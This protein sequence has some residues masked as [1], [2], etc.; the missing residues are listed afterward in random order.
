MPELPEVELQRQR[1]NGWWLGRTLLELHTPDPD[2]L[3][4]AHG[5]SAS[6]LIG[7]T[8]Q[9]VERRAKRLALYF[10]EG[11]ALVV[12]F[13]MT[14]KF[15]RATPRFARLRFVLSDD[16]EILYKDQRRLGHLHLLPHTQVPHALKHTQLG[17][18]PWPEPLS[19]E[20]LRTLFHQ[21]TRRIKEVLLDQNVIAGLGNIAASEILWRARITPGRKASQLGLKRLTRLGPAMVDHIE[22]TLAAE[23]GEEIVFQGEAGSSNPFLIYGR[24]GEPCPRCKSAL[25]QTRHGQRST[26]YCSTCQR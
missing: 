2:R 22:H 24:T 6:Q 16:T 17:P 13:R 25:R 8:L 3:T 11:L 21:D 4:V 12:H 20:T 5:L 7:R 1:L 10:D 18:E 15:V 26:F 9:R 14:G 19:L 23:E